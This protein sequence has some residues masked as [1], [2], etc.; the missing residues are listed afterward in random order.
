MTTTPA[1]RKREF[2]T[3]DALLGVDIGMRDLATCGVR[4]IPQNTELKEGE[5]DAPFQIFDW[6][7]NDLQTSSVSDACLRL[8]HLIYANR[9]LWCSCDHVEE[10]LQSAMFGSNMV[11]VAHSFQSAITG[12]ALA[13]GKKPPVVSFPS[14]V[15][16]LHPFVEAGFELPFDDQDKSKTPAQRKRARKKNSVWVCEKIL[17]DILHDEANY[18]KI[19]HADADHKDDLADSFV[20]AVGPIYRWMNEQ[21]KQRAKELRKR[22]KM[23]K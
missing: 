5:I 8:T 20:Y 10:E 7:L 2:K 12:I 9:E 14:S 4:V 19:R 6:Q 3:G 21:K 17:K 13:E 18:Y 11:A 15:H 1:S 22:A 16:K 23:P